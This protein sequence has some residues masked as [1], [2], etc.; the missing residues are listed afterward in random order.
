M[1]SALATVSCDMGLTI[2]V[3]PQTFEGDIGIFSH[4]LVSDHIYLPSSCHRL[5]QNLESKKL[6]SGIVGHSKCSSLL[7]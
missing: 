5:S 2:T 4:W 7:P 3:S 1:F 6:I